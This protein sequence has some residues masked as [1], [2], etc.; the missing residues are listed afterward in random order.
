MRDILSASAAVGLGAWASIAGPAH[1]STFL[2]MDLDQLV[3]ASDAVVVGDVVDLKSY[4]DAEGRV[5]LTEATVEVDERL[6][7]R[8]PDVV[9]VT[10]FGGKVDDYEIV[11]HGFPVFEVG[12]R[13]A[14]FL[15]RHPDRTVRVTGYQLGHY[16]VVDRKGVAM[17]QPTV[18]GGTSLVT[19]DGRTV[20][21]PA[22]RT[23]QTLRDEIRRAAR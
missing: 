11:A 3:D 18:D 13:V 2:A 16:R 17:V 15:E 23:L 10:T 21:A 9:H 4:W 7:G 1:A 6:L 22:T 20:A 14:L 19:P 5:I 8:V 12:D